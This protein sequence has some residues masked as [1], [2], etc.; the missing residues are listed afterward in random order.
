MPLERYYTPASVAGRLVSLVHPEKYA[1]IIE[2]SAG[3]GAILKALTTCGTPLPPVYAYDLA[4]AAE[5]IETMNWVEPRDRYGTPR[6]SMYTP[7]AE[8]AQQWHHALVIGN[9][10]FSLAERFIRESLF[11]DTIA[12]ILPKSFMKS[13]HAERIIGAHHYVEAIEEIPETA[14]YRLPDGQT[15][16]VPTCMCV[17]QWQ[18]AE[19]QETPAAR[20]LP[21]VF[22]KDPRKSDFAIIRVGGKAGTVLTLEEATSYSH[23][24]VQYV[25]GDPTP[26]YE[27]EAVMQHM[28]EASTGAK[29]INQREIRDAVLRSKSKAII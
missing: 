26:F 24:T 5:G 20:E 21:F 11:A 19:R 28:A 18:A 1:C 13:G 17:F 23:E 27:A 14:R 22:V 2:P 10:P 4:P 7:A 16:A 15:A 6:K 8:K 3:D 25:Q 9:P 29:V 12:F